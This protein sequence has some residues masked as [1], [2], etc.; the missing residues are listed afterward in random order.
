MRYGRWKLL[1][2]G[3]AYPMAAFAEAR[4]VVRVQDPNKTPIAAVRVTVRDESTAGFHGFSDAQGTITFPLPPSGTHQFIAEKEGFYATRSDLVSLSEEAE[5]SLTLQPIRELTESID[6]SAP[7]P[8]VSLDSSSVRRHLT[9]Q[10]IINI[11]YPNTNDLRS[12]LRSVPGL[13]R[14]SRGGLHLNGAAEDQVLYTLNGFN[15]NDPLTGRF[16]SRLSVESVHSVEVTSGNLPAEF[17]KGSGGALAIRSQPGDDRM[18]YSATNFFPGFENRKGWMIGDWTPR[19]GL[20]G[21]I[22]RGRAWLS[23]S[24]DVQYVKTVVRE[25][26]KGEDRYSG[27]RLSNLLSTQINLSPSHILHAGFLTN[28]WNSAR[29]GLTA[30]DPL[31]TTIDRRSRQWFF[32]VKNQLYLR[33]R[34]LI[35]VGYAA[36][37]TFGREIPQGHRMLAFTSHG[38]RGNYYIDGTRKAGREQVLV[39]V[40]LPSFSAAGSHQVKTGVD[41]DHLAYWQDVRRTGFENYSNGGLRTTRTIFGGNGRAR[42]AN[43]EASLYL[44]DSWRVRPRL[45]V[46]AGLRGDWDRI[47][48][49]WN[50]S[51]RVGVAWSPTGSGNTKLYGGLARI[52]DATNLRLFTRPLDQ[53]SLTSY[54]SPDG[55][56]GRGPA[57]SLFTIQNRHLARPRFHTWSLGGAHAWSNG[58]TVRADLLR[59]R[60]A[61]GF[62]YKSVVESA[63]EP[64]PAWAAALNARVLDSVYDLANHRTDVFDSASI[65]V[66]HAIRRQYEWAASYTRSR[67]L[68]NAVVDVSVEDPII[69]TDNVGPMPWDSP[70]RFV[71]WGYLPL[72]RKDWA[73]AFFVDGRSGFPFS[74]QSDEGR[75]LGAVNSNRFPAFFE[76]NLHLERRFV[77]RHHRWAFRFGCNNLTDRINPDSVNP[78][79]SAPGG[80]RFFGG[81]GRSFN[82]RIR[83]L[84]RANI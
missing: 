40:F 22:R 24:A 39:N 17:G 3:L 80:R 62:T 2:A 71:G 15:L 18:R 11:P 6:V 50:T 7:P 47:L 21:P 4:I 72:P 20:S 13:V 74:I 53:Y 57:L 55:T 73:V 66:R 23:N 49:Q 67:A 75:I 78:Y 25:L 46:E 31:E 81:T 28:F 8:S 59:R 84:G 51:P 38:K 10:E 1:C 63:D 44:Q 79:V 43:D 37:R 34:T 29:T 68:S 41:L 70:H 19:L 5:I 30:L 83:W 14:D 82:F 26:P 58:F 12:A 9:G 32:H 54:F 77:L 45:L 33:N 52:L 35:E 64:A 27:I 42:R 60:G 36:N 61:R 76:L 56:I 69:V 16:E 65:T 48:R